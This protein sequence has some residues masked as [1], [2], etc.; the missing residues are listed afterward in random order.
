MA[1]IQGTR[2]R[3]E[4]RQDRGRRFIVKPKVCAFCTEKIEIDLLDLNLELFK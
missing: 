3:T 2:N 4:F 1:G